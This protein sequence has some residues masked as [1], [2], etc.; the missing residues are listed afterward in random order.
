MLWLKEE[1]KCQLL[2]TFL[3]TPFFYKQ[4]VS[5]DSRFS[6]MFILL[7]ILASTDAYT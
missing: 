1:M 6:I 5:L 7:E 2:N 4:E 3:F